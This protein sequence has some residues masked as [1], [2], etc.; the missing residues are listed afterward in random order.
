ME[1]MLWIV[2]VF[3]GNGFAL[4]VVHHDG[5]I[6]DFPLHAVLAVAH[7]QVHVAGA[8]IAAEYAGKFA[9][10]GHHGGI[11]DAVGPGNI[12]TA[13]DGVGII[14]PDGR[15]VVFG[16]GLPGNVGQ[17]VTVYDLSHVFS[18]SVFLD[19][20]ERACSPFP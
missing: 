7:I 20:R 4:F 9:L 5:V 19:C 13:D 6:A 12:V 3:V 8:V 10:V 16:A 18:P 11:E 15:I 1:I 17:G 14:A 2:A